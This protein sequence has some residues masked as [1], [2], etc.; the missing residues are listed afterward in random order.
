MMI[1]IKRIHI[2]CSLP[3]K[4]F[5]NV[6]LEGRETETT[7]ITRGGSSGGR[8]GAQFVRKYLAAKQPAGE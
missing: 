2:H 3:E 1:D 6:I 5:Y 7:T 4:R 8:G